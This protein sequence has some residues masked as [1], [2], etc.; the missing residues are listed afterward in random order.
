MLTTTTRQMFDKSSEGT[1]IAHVI[2]IPTD[3]DAN[4][5]LTYYLGLSYATGVPLGMVVAQ[6]G[7]VLRHW[8]SV[9]SI[10]E[11]V[12]VLGDKLVSIMVYPANNP[13][14]SVK[15]LLVNQYALDQKHTDPALD[16][17]R[18]N[19]LLPSE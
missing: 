14:A 11:Y 17:E 8:K 19:I 4:Q 9:A 7:G 15:N 12:A 5:P 18:L 10:E 3:T 13:E 2:R 6:N 16:N 1:F